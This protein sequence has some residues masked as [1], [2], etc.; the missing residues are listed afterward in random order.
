MKIFKHIDWM[1]SA[2]MIA[3]YGYHWNIMGMDARVESFLIVGGWHVISMLV[4]N[5]WLP[6]KKE[7]VR[8]S[9]HWISFFYLVSLPMGSFWI[10]GGLA[11]FMAIFYTCLC[12]IESFSITFRP[13]R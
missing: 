1:I 3:W 11:P 6:P 12:I 4:H 7:T 5:I 10:I 8:N 2:A 9:Y 13:H